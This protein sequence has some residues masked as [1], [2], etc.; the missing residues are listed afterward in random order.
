MATVARYEF[1][2][3][4]ILFSLLCITGV[5]IPVAILYLLN[6]TIRVE[7][8]VDHVYQ[9]LALEALAAVS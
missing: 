1:M 4:W 7:E 9:M 6:G 3:S 8:Q 5:G 2:G